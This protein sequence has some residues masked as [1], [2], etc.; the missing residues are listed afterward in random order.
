MWIK[1]TK[2][3]L[4]RNGTN[5]SGSCRVLLHV[6]VANIQKKVQFID[7]PVVYGRI[8]WRLL[9][10]KLACFVLFCFV[11]FCFVARRSLRVPDRV[12]PLTV[13]AARMLGCSAQLCGRTTIH[14]VS[15]YM[16]EYQGWQYNQG[17]WKINKEAFFKRDG[18]LM[19]GAKA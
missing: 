18:A 9:T 7:R 15:T 13:L 12:M 5:L 14:K 1:F 11:L 19:L 8:K 17:L 3:E 4:S 10:A 6:A 16:F 2:A